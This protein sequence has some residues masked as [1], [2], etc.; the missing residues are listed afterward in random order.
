MCLSLI[1]LQRT[2]F[3]IK[4]YNIDLKIVHAYKISMHPILYEKSQITVQII[5]INSIL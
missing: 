4:N 1:P 5:F 3:H 2:M